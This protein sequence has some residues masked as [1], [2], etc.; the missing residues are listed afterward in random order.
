MLQSHEQDPAFS[1][2]FLI[3][4]GGTGGKVLREF[5]RRLYEQFR[6]EPPGYVQ[7]EY[8]YL[9]SSDGD[10]Q[11]RGP[12]WEVTGSSLR[13]NPNNVLAVNKG[14]DLPHV[15]ESPSR[16]PHIS[17]W[18]GSRDQL[19]DVLGNVSGVNVFGGQRR[20]LGRFLFAYSAAEFEQ[21]V[22]ALSKNLQ[23]DDRGGAGNVGLAFHVVAGLAGGTGS[24]A[25]VDVAAQLRK[26]YPDSIKTRIV[27]YLLLPEP[28][29]PWATPEGYYY[30]NAYGAL[31]ELNALSVDTLWK[32][33]DVTDRHGGE[34][35]KDIYAAISTCYL[36]TNTDQEGAN[37][38]VR[39]MP[40][41]LAQFLYQRLVVLG[42]S[43]NPLQAKEN[44]E[45]RAAATDNPAR[46]G[47]TDRSRRFATFGIKQLVYPEQQ[48]R[49]YLTFSLMERAALALRFGHWTDEDGYVPIER[50]VDWEAKVR[51]AQTLG[52]WHLSRE[53]LQL[54]LPIL[55][56]D[57]DRKT[58]QQA[59]REIRDSVA[60][61]HREAFEEARSKG[62]LDSFDSFRF[63]DREFGKAFS[64]EYQGLGVQDFY[65]QKHQ[66]QLEEYAQSIVGRLDLWARAALRDGSYAVRDLVRWG[67]TVR[68]FLEERRGEIPHRRKRL[69]EVDLTRVKQDLVALK[70]ELAELPELDS[71]RWKLSGRRNQE[72]MSDITN[73]IL[74]N[75]AHTFELY[76]EQLALPFEEALL[77]R[78]LVHSEERVL[79]PLRKLDDQCSQIAESAKE[80][81]ETRKP[82][83]DVTSP[84][85]FTR[86]LIRF[87]DEDAITRHRRRQLLDRD[88][89]ESIAADCRERVFQALE[90]SQGAS[91]QEAT[92]G[93]AGRMGQA[94]EE[95][96]DKRTHETQMQLP[97]DQR[98]LGISILALLA[99]HYPTKKDQEQLAKLLMKHSGVFVE[100]DDTQRNMLQYGADASFG[101]FVVLPHDEQHEEFAVQIQ[102]ALK[103]E[104]GLTNTDE[105]PAVPY[106]MRTSDG[107]PV[108]NELTLISYTHNMPLRFFKMTKWLK[109]H[110]EKRVA[111]EGAFARYVVHAE[112]AGSHVPELYP[113]SEQQFDLVVRQHLLI[114]QALGCVSVTEA[115]DGPAYTV[116]H[117]DN[118]GLELQLRFSGPLHALTG[119]DEGDGGKLLEVVRDH[120]ANRNGDARKEA[121]EW[122]LEKQSELRSSAGG[123]YDALVLPALR[124]ALDMAKTA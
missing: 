71:L 62:N 24:G 68:G 47:G 10:L 17:S 113:L 67:K 108:M 114:G 79:E 33:H 99:R 105:F 117:Y 81:M 86:P 54:Q 41:L 14:A 29:S 93:L 100:L 1:N 56:T 46:L 34:R 78:T 61:D 102:E 63:F 73:R 40:G 27:L 69:A 103:A 52:S 57:R 72:V 107:V 115:A 59:W 84:K 77:E 9:D 109:E 65:A 3:G 101:R 122:L 96:A 104:G 7:F 120:L 36:F 82:L 60:A 42:N 50:T 80:R 48:V 123:T 111:R 112:G 49:E 11:M 28:N 45:N 87:V 92:G 90:G 64:R 26:M 66:N 4:L 88:L 15:L 121:R 118:D 94:L 18:M 83:S 32:P 19:R 97:A 12:E 16:Y 20:R 25:I 43:V 39:Q 8:L 124:A 30:E 98:L 22:F 55:D 110:Y 106:S 44:L 21:R 31:R 85:A 95:I 116:P 89:Q 119:V 2:H 76:T 23:Q 37:R 53:H 74:D 38:Q 5:R 35:L 13:L 58:F 51:E 6:E 75:Y 70:E 91:L